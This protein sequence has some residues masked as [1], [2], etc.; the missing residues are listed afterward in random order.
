MVDEHQRPL[1]TGSDRQVACQQ[2]QPLSHGLAESRYHRDGQHARA[3]Q[4]RIGPSG[5]FFRSCRPGSDANPLPRARRASPLRRISGV[6]DL[7]LHRHVALRAVNRKHDKFGRILRIETVTNDVSFFKHHRTVEHRDGTRETQLAPVK[8]TIHS[9]GVLLSCS[10]PPI[11]ATLNSFSSLDDTTTGRKE[12]DRLS[13]PVRDA[14][15]SYKGLNF[16]DPLDSELL[17]AIVRGE[18]NIRGSRTSQAP[19]SP[20]GSSGRGCTASSRGSTAPTA[21]TSPAPD[22]APSPLP[23]N[24]VR[25]VSSQPSPQL[26]RESFIVVLSEIL[27]VRD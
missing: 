11:V 21:T 7:L 5:P 10:P 15:R 9:L 8:K 18:F 13:R 14:N 22:A 17:L 20:A 4:A 6:T 25:P 3:Q 23:C 24:S 26:P 2:A 19:R 16:F 27:L 1:A 12:L